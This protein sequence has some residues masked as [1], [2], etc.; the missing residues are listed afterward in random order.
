MRAAAVA[1]CLCVTT[2]AYANE[3][4]GYFK[5]PP[6]E[7]ISAIS[8]ECTAR[9]FDID[10]LSNTDVV[11]QGNLHHGDKDFRAGAPPEDPRKS[12]L[13]QMFHHFTAE[14]SPSGSVVKESTT[15][16]VYTHGHWYEPRV[17]AAIEEKRRVEFSFPAFIERDIDR[18]VMEFLQSIGGQPAPLN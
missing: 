16:V 18:K 9:K 15:S 11:C 7:V 12:R 2:P 14:A 1:I 8:A 10:R 13:G 17:V 3:V 6:S 4:V 5:S